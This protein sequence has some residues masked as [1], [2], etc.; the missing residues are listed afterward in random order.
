MKPPTDETTIRPVAASRWTSMLSGWPIQVVLVLLAA[1]MIHWPLLGSA[2][3]SGTEGHRAIPGYH[4]LE[5]GDWLVP[6]LFGRPY[7]RK[8]P[9]M[10]WAIA[11]ASAL[12]GQTELAARAVSAMAATAAAVLALIFARRWFGAIGGLYAGLAQVFMPV[13]WSSARS[14]DIDSLHNLGVQLASLSALDIILAQGRRGIGSH[15]CGTLALTG[16]LVLAALAKGPAGA[17]AFASVLI[18]GILFHRSARVLF[19]PGIGAGLV[20]SA[21]ILSVIY[22]LIAQRTA[23]LPAAPVL[24]TVDDFLWE[25]GQ[26]MRILLLMP[27]SLLMATPASLAMLFPW[28]PDAFAEA[29]SPKAEETPRAFPAARILSLAVLI[30]LGMLTIAG[31]SNPRYTMATQMLIAPIAGYFGLGLHGFFILKRP[32]IAQ[33]ML[34]G[35]PMVMCIGMLLAGMVTVWLSQPR[36]SRIGGR[37]AG[38]KIAGVIS[39][40]S[41]IWADHLIEARPDVLWYASNGD[42]QARKVEWKALSADCPVPPVNHYLILRDDPQA[43]ELSRYQQAGR[44]SRLEEVSAG[45]VY[46]YTFRVFRVRE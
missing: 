26:T 14:A 12:L 31:V 41:N 38:A 28:G 46:Q 43:G 35:H 44:M 27:T 1:G 16:G 9:G 33:S 25:P 29:R 19:R 2:S 8:P 32:P 7:L 21:V 11:G 4:M 37:E 45:S 17:T 36:L 23:D 5:G 39:P 40:G 15:V 42:G 10:P 22:M 13:F 30:S 3:F 20:L 6:E 18:A 24:Q 34:L